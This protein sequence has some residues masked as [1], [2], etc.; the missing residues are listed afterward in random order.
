MST[1]K[2]G[3]KR[4]RF[5]FRG[6]AE[7][8]DLVP[9]AQLALNAKNIPRL[10]EARAFVAKVRAK[11]PELTNQQLDFN[12]HSL[13]GFIAE[14][15]GNDY[16]GART[17]TIEA[18]APVLRRGSDTPRAF[19]PRDPNAPLPTR[20]IRKDG[21]KEMHF[22]NFFLIVVERPHHCGREES[23]ARKASRRCAREQAWY[24]TQ[25]HLVFC[26]IFFHFRSARE[27]FYF[28]LHSLVRVAQGPSEA[29]ADSGSMENR[30]SEGA[31]RSDSPESGTARGRRAPG[32]RPTSQE[33][34]AR[35]R[36]QGAHRHQSRGTGGCK[37][38]CLC[39][40]GG[41]C[42]GAVHQEGG[43]ARS[44]V[45]DSGSGSR[46]PGRKE[47][48]GCNQATTLTKSK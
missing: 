5:A 10:N 7:L 1:E 35:S 29:L 25:V 21:K 24:H 22:A 16:P 30:S 39:A 12:G 37:T 20:Y 45:G 41:R 43:G 34:R 6:T 33:R 40:Q 31:S 23:G 27:P 46:S 15:V 9:D 8:R 48:S 44:Q 36:F 2:D 18:G 13:G 28:Q 19:H 14:G 42:Q 38:C 32:R 17:A 26:L 3:S 47:S 4:L 11:H